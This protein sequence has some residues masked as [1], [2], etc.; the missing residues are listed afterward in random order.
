MPRVPTCH[1]LLHGLSRYF[2][3]AFFF[4]R[5]P[6]PRASILL[7]GIVF[8]TRGIQ[9]CNFDSFIGG[10]PCRLFRLTVCV[11][12]W[13]CFA[14]LLFCGCVVGLGVYTRVWLGVYACVCGVV[15][16]LVFLFVRSLSARRAWEFRDS[17]AH[18]QHLTRPSTRMARNATSFRI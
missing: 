16:V 7:V 5:V 17:T 10:A 3:C 9:K 4:H 14:L 11:C 1:A 6:R 18:A 2:L 15:L 8:R 13:V 12:V